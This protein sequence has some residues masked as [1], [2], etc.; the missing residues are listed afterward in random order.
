MLAC[1]RLQGPL[2]PPIR[3]SYLQIPRGPK[4]TH[5]TLNRRAV[6]GPRVSV[7]KLM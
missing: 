4:M 6:D 5:A 7:S 3:P 2:I 1:G